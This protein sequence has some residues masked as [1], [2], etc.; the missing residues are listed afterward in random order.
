MYQYL[1]EHPNH[2]IACIYLS[3][4]YLH[5]PRLNERQ[6]ATSLSSHEYATERQKD[7]YMQRQV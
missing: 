3:L 5:P 4:L 1:L 2:R 7:A 6:E